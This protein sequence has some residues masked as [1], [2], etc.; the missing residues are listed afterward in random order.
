MGRVLVLHLCDPGLNPTVGSY[1]F[2][3]FFLLCLSRIRDN[4]PVRINNLH[5][6]I[7]I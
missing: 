7:T 6:I 2:F 5:I 3:C 4:H 1:I